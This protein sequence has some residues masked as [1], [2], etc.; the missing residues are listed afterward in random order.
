MHKQE[1]WKRSMNLRM[2]IQHLSEKTVYLN[3]NVQ[4]CIELYTHLYDQGYEYEV[5]GI[6]LLFVSSCRYINTNIFIDS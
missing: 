4:K 2:S 3:W 1:D 5:G 6:K